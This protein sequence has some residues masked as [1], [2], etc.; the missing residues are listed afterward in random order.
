MSVTARSKNIGISAKKIRPLINLLRG[1][2]ATDALDIL[3]YI[4]SSSSEILLQ[5][6]KS[7]IANAESNQYGNKDNLVI[8]TILADQSSE[9]KRWR[10]SARGRA[11]TFNRPQAHLFVELKDHTVEEES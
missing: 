9:I 3:S 4:S 2:K 11:G 10:A 8:S 7:A 5:L 6:I 1:K